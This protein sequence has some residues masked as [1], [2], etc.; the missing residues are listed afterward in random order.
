MTSGSAS[1]LGAFGSVSGALSA[2]K[3]SWPEERPL[4]SNAVLLIVDAC[5]FCSDRV[6]SKPGL[7]R[8]RPNILARTRTFPSSWPRQGPAT[9]RSRRGSGSPAARLRI[10]LQRFTWFRSLDSTDS[11]F[12]TTNWSLQPVG[13]VA[14]ARLELGWAAE[15]WMNGFGLSVFMVLT[16]FH[17]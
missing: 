14:E 12:G 4:A 5:S 16:C 3:L 11:R 17:A 15:T 13:A 10:E 9:T 7:P 6:P 1:E 2:W 8:V